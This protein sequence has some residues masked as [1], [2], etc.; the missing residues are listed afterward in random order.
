MTKPVHGGGNGPDAKRVDDAGVMAHAYALPLVLWN[1]KSVCDAWE[2]GTCLTRHVP[3]AERCGPCAKRADE[4][5]RMAPCEGCGPTL[6]EA[7]REDV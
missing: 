2:T 1:A 5:Q 7:T 4:W 3:V 6:S